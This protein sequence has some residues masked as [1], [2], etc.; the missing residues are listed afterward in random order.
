[1][2]IWLRPSLTQNQG[3]AD[4]KWAADAACSSDHST[5]GMTNDYPV[6]QPGL[7][8]RRYYQRCFGNGAANGSRCP[9]C[10]GHDAWGSVSAVVDPFVG[11]QLLA[12]VRRARIRSTDQPALV[13]DGNAMPGNTSDRA[14]A[15]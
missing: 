13:D 12:V 4:F 5:E 3:N 6:L 14:L 2:L 9:A 15:D 8:A 1:M 10:P 11:Y 7:P